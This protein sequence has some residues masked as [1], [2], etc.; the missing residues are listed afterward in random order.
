M[1]VAEAVIDPLE[2]IEVY[3]N[4]GEGARVLHTEGD[5]TRSG[6]FDG[7]AI[8]QTCE[9]VSGGQNLEILAKSGCSHPNEGDGNAALHDGGFEEHPG[10]YGPT[11]HV[12]GRSAVEN[13]S[14]G[15][16]E[17]IQAEKGQNYAHKTSG[18]SQVAGYIPKD[19]EGAERK[20][21]AE[22][23]AVSDEPYCGVGMEPAVVSQG[24]ESKDDEAG[25]QL[26]LSGS[27]PEELGQAA[28]EEEVGNRKETCTEDD[29]EGIRDMPTKGDE[30]STNKGTEVIDWEPIHALGAAVEPGVD[31]G[32]KGIKA[33]QDRVF[34]VQS[35]HVH[36]SGSLL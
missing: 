28:M 34:N 30:H 21:N 9:R 16:N 31:Q 26:P 23:E 33:E 20:L 32:E 13:C 8:E 4:R 25:L 35:M 29:R 11:V 5:L 14:D 18:Y 22:D 7:S 27:L 12:V 3:E 17:V 2:A 6:V 19:E 1:Q 15:S 10:K 36:R 24:Y